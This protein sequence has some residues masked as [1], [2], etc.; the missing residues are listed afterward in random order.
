VTSYAQAD[1]HRSGAECL[2][3]QAALQIVPLPAYG[4]Q[5]AFDTD[6]SLWGTNLDSGEVNH[7]SQGQWSV[8]KLPPG[9]RTYAITA[10]P[11]HG[12][13]I[14]TDR[15]LMYTDGQ[16][17]YEMPDLDLH[18]PGGS[19]IDVAIESS[20]AVWVLTNESKL[21]WLP[22]DR[23][24]GDF[25]LLT[26]VSARSVAAAADGVWITHG[27]DL[28]HLKLGER[29]PASIPLPEADCRLD[30]LTAAPNGDVWATSRCGSVWQYQPATSHWIR[31]VVEAST[32]DVTIFEHVEIVVAGTDGSV[33]AIGPTGFV[34]LTEPGGAPAGT[35]ESSGGVLPYST[36]RYHTRLLADGVAPLSGG[37]G[38]ADRH[39]GF[40]LTTTNRGNLWHYVNGQFAAV[41]HPFRATWITTLQVDQA[42]RLW[43]ANLYGQLAVYDGQQWRTFSTPGIGTVYRIAAASDG[44][45][46][47][48][49]NQGIALYDPAQDQQ[50]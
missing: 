11:S 9:A 3:V 21:S 25:K 18:L 34:V 42:D 47:F 29:I 26:S 8:I 20:G 16:A 38:T 48:G 41:E 36:Y 32:P 39:G 2:A 44:R 7:W 17:L 5:L 10:D 40:W 12:V 37:P 4:S 50:P 43:A 28:I 45:L 27:T 49:G 15:G 1:N 46:W 33:Y 13:W 30:R 24:A 19:P 14:G 23:S 22:A 31:N 35:R 6:G